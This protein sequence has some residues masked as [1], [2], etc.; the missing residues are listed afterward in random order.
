RRSWRAR[1][2][3]SWI[4][5]SF[6]TWRSSSISRRSGPPPSTRA[7]I[8]PTDSRSG[9]A[10]E[11]AGGVRPRPVSLAG[12]AGRCPGLARVGTAQPGGAAPGLGQLPAL[13][14][15]PAAATAHDREALPAVPDD[16]PPGAAA[17]PA[18]LRDVPRAR[19]G[20]PPRVHREVPPL[21]VRPPLRRRAPWA[22]PP[23]CGRTIGGPP[24]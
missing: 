9:P 19:S 22:G 20:S 7:R 10:D 1:P 16:A 17:P 24:T 8:R 11:G 13:P 3:C 18:E 12:D 4:C 15:A 14:A 6:G 23:A 21:E 5:P 2:T